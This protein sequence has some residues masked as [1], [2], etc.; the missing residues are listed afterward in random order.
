MTELKDS[1]NVVNKGELSF[2]TNSTDVLPVAT[3]LTDNKLD[4]TNFFEWSKT[5]RI[6]L[7]TIGKAS[8]LTS[9][10]P[11]DE[12][13]DHWIQNDARLFLQ[14]RNSI[15][16][17]VISLINH[18]EYVK[19]LMDYLDFLYSE[20]SNMSRIYNVCKSFHR[21][22]Q[23]D[24]SIIAY[25][26]EFKKT[27]EELNALLPISTDVR[28][29]QTQREQIAVLSFLTGLRPEFDAIRSQF[30]NEPTIPSLQETFARIL[31]HEPNISSPPP[32]ALPTSTSALV[33]RGGFRGGFRGGSRG[34]YRGDHRGGSRGN[35]GDRTST[36]T[37]EPGQVECF[38]CHELGHTKYNCKKLLA[39]QS[40]GSAHLAAAFDDNNT[41]PAEEN[42][43]P[44][45]TP[46]ATF[47]ESGKFA[48]SLVSTAPKWVIDSGASEHMT[49][50]PQLLS[51]FQKHAP[52]PYVTIADGSTPKVLGS[53]N[54]SITPSIHLSSV[55][56]LPNFPFNLLSV[57]KITRGLNC[58]ALFLPDS[59]VFQ[60]LSTKRI[61]GKGREYDGLYILETQTPYSLACSN[62]LPFEAHCRLGHP[63]LQSL[64]KLCP[65]FSHLSS[66]QCESCQLAKHQ[67]VYLSP[68]VNKRATFPFEL[69]HS[70][71]WGPCSVP[72]KLGF[73]YFV[74]F[75]DDYSCVTWLYFMKNRSEVFSH[76]CSL[77]TKVKTHFNVSIRTLRSDN[78][79]EYFSESFRSFCLQNGIVHESSCIHTPTQNGVAER[80]NRHL[81]EVARALLFQMTV[82]KPFW[83]NAV[84]TACFLINRM[85]SIVLNGDIPFLV[86]CPEKPLYPIPPKI[87]GSTCF[88]H[89]THSHPTK[90]DPKSVKCV[91]VGYCRVQKGYRSTLQ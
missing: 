15:D 63:S 60:D 71:V 32:S 7:R 18:C 4:D 10:P 58:S 45:G 38:Y 30:L 40:K 26:M 77:N 80:K 48:K 23:L 61:I 86:L 21:G 49:G 65:E 8:H 84:S 50:D 41:V 34:G 76:F 68:R 1:S 17:S 19:E 54:A 78:A 44:T 88:V 42:S 55:L 70:D 83:A 25:V 29:M 47:A 79:K 90:L 20:E 37:T 35:Y 9:D 87:F 64:K 28:V 62:S 66:L 31:R 67:R 36:T 27:Y 91:F 13:K 52:L 6:Y 53:G 12:S 81:L 69:V 59:C 33:G 39:R 24:R 5:V 51:D 14:I 72:S 82:P 89:D 56:N 46:V 22:E 75:I 43:H 2:A 85:P 11:T 73:K 16:T 74:T 3:R 57:S